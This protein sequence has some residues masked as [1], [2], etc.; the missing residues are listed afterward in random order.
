MYFEC[1]DNEFCLVFRQAFLCYVSVG[2]YLQNLN[3]CALFT[4]I[5]QNY[6]RGIVIA[7]VKMES[8]K[9]IGT[10]MPS[11]NQT[12]T[13]QIKIL[14]FV[15]T[16]FHHVVEKLIASIL[17]IWNGYNVAPEIGLTTIIHVGKPYW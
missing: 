16:I 6:S 15:L 13:W 8:L 17:F 2:S 12:K 9:D 3:I 4:N 10:M 1:D 7:F 5:L 14:L 11:P